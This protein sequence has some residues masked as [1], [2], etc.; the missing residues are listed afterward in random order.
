MSSPSE[1]INIWVPAVVVALVVGILAA[2]IWDLGRRRVWTFFAQFFPC[3]RKEVGLDQDI[4]WLN[5]S[6]LNRNTVEQEHREVNQ[7]LTESMRSPTLNGLV[8]SSDTAQPGAHGSI[9]E[10]LASSSNVNFIG[11]THDEII[12]ISETHHDSEERVSLMDSRS[13]YVEI[14]IT[15]ANSDTFGHDAPIRSLNIE[16][17]LEHDDATRSTRSCNEEAS[18]SGSSGFASN[19]PLG[20]DNFH[21]ARMDSTPSSNS[22]RSMFM[23]T[24]YLPGQVPTPFV[25]HVKEQLHN[26]ARRKIRQWKSSVVL[27]GLLSTHPV[28]LAKAVKLLKECV[29]VDKSCTLQLGTWGLLYFKGTSFTKTF[30]LTFIIVLYNLRLTSTCFALDLREPT[31]TLGCLNSCLQGTSVQVGSP[32]PLALSA[33]K[34]TRCRLF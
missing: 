23:A 20:P 4:N 14:N 24:Y 12:D 18:A 6:L 26:L 15:S 25:S 9:N 33:K 30:T 19:N 28:V 2:A 3:I 29:E 16:S 5:N 21:Y 32:R 27:Q 13:Q 8:R 1:K 17:N 31:H 22:S 34:V 10:E 11:P 7:D